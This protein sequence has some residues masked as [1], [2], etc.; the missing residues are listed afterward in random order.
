MPNPDFTIPYERR[1]GTFKDHIFKEKGRAGFYILVGG[2]VVFRCYYRH[3][4]ITDFM[5]PGCRQAVFKGPMDCSSSLI[6]KI[7]TF[8]TYYLY[9]HVL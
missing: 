4:D 7:W 8:T 9:L 3:G 2:K 6:N 5:L 1:L